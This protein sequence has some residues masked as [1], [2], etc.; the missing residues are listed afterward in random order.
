MVSLPSPRRPSPPPLVPPSTRT[1]C[2]RDDDDGRWLPSCNHLVFG[3]TKKSHHKFLDANYSLSTG[4]FHLPSFWNPLL[5]AATIYY[6]DIRPPSER[7]LL[8][9]SNS[10]CCSFH[11][12]R[13]YFFVLLFSGV[14]RLASP[15]LLTKH[16]LL[17]WTRRQTRSSSRLRCGG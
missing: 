13:L 10:R 5:P 8:N 11:H 15:R 4:A 6:F 7:N 12:H 9:R 16:S 1:Y 14:V 3:W 17:Q 2:I